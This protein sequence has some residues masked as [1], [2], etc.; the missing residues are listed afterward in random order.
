M[1]VQAQLKW[2]SGLR[3][4]AQVGDGPTITLDS[5]EGGGGPTPMEVLLMGVGGCTAMDVISI[6][7]KKRAQVAGMEI[8]LNGERAAEHPQRY[9]RI[10][11]EY[12]V[13]GHEIKPA[14]VERAIELSETKYCGARASLNAEFS[15]SYRIV[16]SEQGQ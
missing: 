7:Q 6:L 11:I 2:V 15:S 16:E 13:Y 10:H 4:T 3:F 5:H 12:V 1:A 14:D 8:N 9:T